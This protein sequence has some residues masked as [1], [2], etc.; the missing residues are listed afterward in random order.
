MEMETSEAGPVKRRK[1]RGAG[2]A[3][4]ALKSINSGFLK[5]CPV[6]HKGKMFSSYWKMR[7][8]CPN[9]G[10]KFERESGEYI[11]AMYIN[12]GLTE[13]IFISGYIVTNFVL[14][15]DMWTQ[16]AIWAPFTLL[17]PIFFYP[18]SKGL[19]AGMLNIMGGLYPD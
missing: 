15:L 16:I 3:T 10:A 7:D 9:C 5:R 12:I 19:W 18:H 14:E 4:F 17:F 8:Y 2:M 6:C 1:L 11:V 13:L